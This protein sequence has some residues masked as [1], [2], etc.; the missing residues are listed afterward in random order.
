MIDT[1]NIT[2]INIVLQLTT[3]FML[4]FLFLIAVHFMDLF[5]SF[6]SI[7]NSVNSPILWL[8]LILVAGACFLFDYTI[9]SIN[10]M[11]NPNF[12]KE[13]QIIHSRY[14]TINSTKR[15]SRRM[16]K[17]L[18]SKI[19]KQKENNEDQ[20]NRKERKNINVIRENAI[21]RKHSHYQKEFVIQSVS[22]SKEV[23]K[24]NKSNNDSLGS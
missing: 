6:A 3:T 24:S 11:F 19:N 8:N 14:G 10:Y 12:A 22:H 21:E 2:W 16:V 9:K 17:M 1:A 23:S 20:H 7:Y 15:L 4:Y 5:N 18:K 13:L